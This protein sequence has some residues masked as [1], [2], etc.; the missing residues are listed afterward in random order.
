MAKTIRYCWNIGTQS[1]ECIYGEDYWELMH[2][3][4]EFSYNGI[5]NFGKSDWQILEDGEWETT[6][7]PSGSSYGI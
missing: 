3:V 5:N 1:E 7:G 2:Q 4:K 6:S